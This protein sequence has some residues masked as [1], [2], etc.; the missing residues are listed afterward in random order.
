M[1]TLTSS[2]PVG[3]V[4]DPTQHLSGI[5]WNETQILLYQRIFEFDIDG[6]SADFSFTKRLARENG[7]TIAYTNR[8]VRH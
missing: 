2:L 4:P 8:V 1:T 6:G 3:N 5:D 7:W